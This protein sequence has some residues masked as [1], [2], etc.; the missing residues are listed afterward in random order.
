M[1]APK[2]CRDADDARIRQC[3]GDAAPRHA[4]RRAVSPNG[5]TPKWLIWRLLGRELQDVGMGQSG[6]HDCVHGSLRLSAGWVWQRTPN[7][8]SWGCVRLC[9]QQTQRGLLLIGACPMPLGSRRMTA[10]RV[11]EHFPTGRAKRVFAQAVLLVVA[12]V[13]AGCLGRQ[14]AIE[15]R[16][17]P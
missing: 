17:R 12:A 11:G 9:C 4:C 7:F 6:A 8:R 3:H 10:H 5:L 16:C 1:Q 15:P 13:K 14:T 2:H